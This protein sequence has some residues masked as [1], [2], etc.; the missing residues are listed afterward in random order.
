MLITLLRC[1]WET[2]EEKKRS[3]WYIVYIFIIH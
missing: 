1:V 3:I 2:T